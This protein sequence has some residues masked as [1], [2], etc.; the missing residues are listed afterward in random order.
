[1]LNIDSKEDQVSAFVF[2]N[3]YNY[4]LK[5]FE[6]LNEIDVK[7]IRNVVTF[8]EKVLYDGNTRREELL[9]SRHE[10]RRFWLS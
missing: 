9:F 7:N 6:Y 8:E 1:V 10:N 5:H 4:Y 3:I 2:I